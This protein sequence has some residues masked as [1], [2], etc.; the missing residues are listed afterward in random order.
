MYT[1]TQYPDALH[2]I[3]STTSRLASNPNR[4]EELWCVP[5]CI[6]CDMLSGKNIIHRPWHSDWLDFQLSWT[7]FG[8]IVVV[9][10]DTDV[11]LLYINPALNT[12]HTKHHKYH[13][14][15]HTCRL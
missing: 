3:S 14:A 13:S 12:E 5:R 8:N 11:W 9:V 7:E 6:L 15:M 4:P 2:V 10:A 1:H